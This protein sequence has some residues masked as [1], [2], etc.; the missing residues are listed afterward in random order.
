MAYGTPQS[1]DEVEAYYT[2]IRHGHPPTPE[3]LADLVRRY[4]A[5]GGVSP[6]TA[7]TRRQAEGIRYWLRHR[8]PNVD[9]RIYLGMRHAHPFI[10]DVVREM[11][12]DGITHAVSLVLAP[13]YATMSIGAYQRAAEQASDGRLDWQHIDHW[14]LHPGY[15]QAVAARVQASLRAFP[16]PGG[17]TVVF[18]AHSL[19]ERILAQGDPYPQQIRETGE[20]VKQQLGLEQVRFGWQSMG[21]TSERWLGPDILQVLDELA[22]EGVQDVLVCP[23]GFVADHLE[24][25]YDLDIEARNH[26]DRLGMRFARTPSLNDAPEFTA[27]LADVVATRWEMSRG[28]TTG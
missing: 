13:H 3:L 21:R 10:S 22:S 5:I 4:Q 27:A 11:L 14:H 15:L 18:T 6:L 1:L 28:G 19:P 12:R 25:L 2:H 8:Q 20:A 17:V 9:W 16:D 26:A 7:I 23:V 24:V